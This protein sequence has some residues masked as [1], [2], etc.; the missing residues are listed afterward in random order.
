MQITG[1]D[2]YGI[3]DQRHY[4]GFTD[5]TLSL[6][7]LDR[8]DFLDMSYFVDQR[9]HPMI[10]VGKAG[11][12]SGKRKGLDSTQEE[13]DDEEPEEVRV[14]DLDENNEINI[15]GDEQVDIGGE[16]ALAGPSSGATDLEVAQDCEE[17]LDAS[18]FRGSSALIGERLNVTPS[19]TRRDPRKRQRMES[20][21]EK[22]KTNLLMEML[23]QDREDNRRARQ[24][25]R[26]MMK[27]FLTDTMPGLVVGIAKEVFNTMR[28]ANVTP[29]QMIEPSPSSQQLRLAGHA[30][31]SSDSAKQTPRGS[32]NPSLGTTSSDP[33]VSASTP[34]SVE[35]RNDME[36]EAAEVDVTPVANQVED[37]IPESQLGC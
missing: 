33:S 32:K 18:Q 10:G 1:M 15:G 27:S 26:D 13:E 11:S 30:H 16:D 6:E 23:L 36:L 37:A 5:L 19:S 24:E 12:T 20:P 34:E 31:G 3:D 22:S 29:L 17:A 8:D 4:D 28:M 2:H 7:Y 25:D 35:E 9:I 14:I 21:K